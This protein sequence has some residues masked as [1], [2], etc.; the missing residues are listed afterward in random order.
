M[1]KGTGSRK[2][3]RRRQKFK[4]SSSKGSAGETQETDAVLAIVLSHRCLAVNGRPFARSGGSRFENRRVVI[5]WK[6]GTISWV[7]GSL[8]VLKQEVFLYPVW[9]VI[10]QRA[11]PVARKS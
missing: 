6:P 1:R 9:H 7:R 11:T 3:Y 5:H 10:G 4:A 8:T 2:V